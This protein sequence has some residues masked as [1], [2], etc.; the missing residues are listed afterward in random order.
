[1]ETNNTT[2]IMIT[3]G[4]GTAQPD[5]AGNTLAT[6][7]DIGVLSGTQTFQDFVQPADKNDYYKFTL[8]ASASFSLRLDNLGA[9]A[10]VQLLSSTGSV[11]AS[12]TNGGTTPEPISRTLAAGTYFVRVFPYNG[13]NTAYTL[14]LAAGAAPADGAGNT[15][16]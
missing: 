10:D 8:E 11:I 14:T 13:A 3:I 6:A 1:N 16:G 5:S 4:G 2:R 9:D 15:L 12:S 7:R